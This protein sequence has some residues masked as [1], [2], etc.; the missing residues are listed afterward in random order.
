MRRAAQRDGNEMAI[1]TAL[2][3][4]GCSI[5]RL[6]TKGVPDLLVGWHGHN[7]LLEVKDPHAARGPAQATRLTP[8]QVIWHSKWKGQAHIVQSEVEAI[9]VMRAIVG[10]TVLADLED[11]M[12]KSQEVAGGK[13]ATCDLCPNP[14]TTRWG[15]QPL[16]SACRRLSSD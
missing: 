2:E 11:A 16:C 1:V 9:Q 15:G 3:A 7:V 4:L 10:P 13:R 6:S 12:R 14:A 8:D 5:Q